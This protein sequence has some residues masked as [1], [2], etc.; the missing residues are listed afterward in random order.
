M[1]GVDFMLV[2]EFSMVGQDMLGLMSARGK[3]AVEGRRRDGD[4][5]RHLDIFGGLS[6]ILVGDPMQLHPVGASPMW[7]A[8]PATAGLSVQ[9]FQSWLGTNNA[10]ELTQVMRQLGPEQA[11]FP[12]T[13]LRVAEGT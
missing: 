6:V 1:N 5:D 4:D 9:G 8:R 13:L 2:D 11:A 10:V 7:A 3:Q 12:G